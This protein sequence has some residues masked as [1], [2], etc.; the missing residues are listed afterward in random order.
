MRNDARRMN[1]KVARHAAWQAVTGRGTK[2]K[3]RKGLKNKELN[4]KK[5]P[6]KQEGGGGETTRCTK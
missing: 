5:N 2:K 3:K 1:K 6:K 4:L